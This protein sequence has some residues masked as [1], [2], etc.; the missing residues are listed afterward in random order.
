MYVHDNHKTIQSQKKIRT[1]VRFYIR[2][3]DNPVRVTKGFI[4]LLSSNFL[5]GKMD[6]NLPAVSMVGVY[7]P[8][9]LSTDA[10]LMVKGGCLSAEAAFPQHTKPSGLTMTSKVATGSSDECVV[11]E[12]LD[13]PNH[14]MGR[15]H[16]SHRN[17]CGSSLMAKGGC[18]SA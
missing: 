5:P 4:F 18:P 17:G 9:P 10:S 8:Q 14:S 1:Y 6:H 13:S 2:T 3:Y 16:S 12:S 11:V 15:V 7:L